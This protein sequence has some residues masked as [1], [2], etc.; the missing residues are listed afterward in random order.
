[1]ALR[2]VHLMSRKNSTLGQELL[3]RTAENSKTFPNYDFFVRLVREARESDQQSNIDLESGKVMNLSFEKR[4][5]FLYQ[6]V[7]E[8]HFIPLKQA[9]ETVKDPEDRKF[10][11]ILIEQ[12]FREV[13]PP[14][15]VSTCCDSPFQECSGCKYEPVPFAIE[16]S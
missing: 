6:M 1:M 12:I 7:E 9:V 8:K 5:D 11:K 10:Y 16:W 13:N 2:L 15:R 14:V 4:V 3:D